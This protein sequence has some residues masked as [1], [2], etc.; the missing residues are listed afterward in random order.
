MDEKR[1]TMGDK[2]WKAWQEEADPRVTRS[3]LEFCILPTAADWRAVMHAGLEVGFDGRKM[4]RSEQHLSS[5]ERERFW[6]AWWEAIAE[7]L[8]DTA[9]PNWEDIFIVLFSTVHKA[10]E[11]RNKALRVLSDNEPEVRES[12][13]YEKIIKVLEQPLT[14]APT[15]NRLQSLRMFMYLVEGE[16]RSEIINELARRAVQSEDCWDEL[17][18]IS[19]D[20]RIAM[21]FRGLAVLRAYETVGG[22]WQQL[23]LWRARAAF[24]R[25]Y[26]RA[27]GV[28]LDMAALLKLNPQTLAPLGKATYPE[29]QEQNTEPD[30]QPAH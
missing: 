25:A 7:Y 5:E 15:R 24:R 11:T 27:H 8:T 21:P 29:P 9:S 28:P 22:L 6:D 3:L 16:K 10:P 4:V 23:R 12:D 1:K 30:E 19:R 20:A 13:Y 26:L 17:V 18:H 2:L 14:H